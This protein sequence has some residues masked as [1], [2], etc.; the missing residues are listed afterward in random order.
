MPEHSRLVKMRIVNFGCI[1]PEGLEIE[2]NNII[3]LV[4]PNNTGKTTV[5]RAYEAAVN[6]EKLNE[7]EI[8]IDADGKTTNQPTSVEIWVHLPEAVTQDYIAEKW[9]KKEGDL[10]LVL[11][12]WEWTF[13]DYKS[14]R[15]TWDPEI[16]DYASDEKAAGFDSKFSSRLP[17]P[18][19]IKALTGPEAEHKALLSLILEPIENKLKSLIEDQNSD[20]KKAMVNVKNEAKK[21]V[22]L[23]N[24][25]IQ[26]IKNKINQ[27][28]TR[29]FPSSEL[30][31]TIDL[32]DIDIKPMT[33]LQNGSQID[34]KEKG[35]TTNYLQQGT[36]AQRALFWS[37][38]E[39][40]S[41]LK[42]TNDEKKYIE[43]KEAELSK[44]IE[45]LT[46][47]R[48]E[49]VKQFAIDKAN[50]ELQKK[51][52]ELVKIQASK[53]GEEEEKRGPIGL[54]GY[55]LLIDEPEIALHPNAIRSAK[56]YLYD[57]ANDSGWH[58]M[59]STHSPAFIDPLKDH[60]TIVRLTR[61][62]THPTPKTY[63]SDTL[64]FAEDDLENLK[65]L[66]KFDTSL[67][68]M[69]FGAYPIIIEGDTEYAAFQKIMEI[70]SDEY[71]MGTRPLLIRSRGK[72]TICLIIKILNHFKVPYSVLHD[73]DS[74]KTKRGEK[75]NSAWSANK[76][77]YNDI[78]DGRKKGIRIIHRVSIPNFELQH[79]GKE[80]ESEKP[81]KM[82]KAVQEDPAIK[83]SIKQILDALNSSEASE[84]PFEGDYLD[85]LKKR[86]REWAQV[87]ASDDLRFD[88]DEKEKGERK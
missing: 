86:V 34:I 50:K 76:R 64:T 88:F 84:G 57:L 68:E 14:V 77:I 83:E 32:E 41:E 8:Y 69:F 42:K 78:L 20:L 30:L 70:Y 3:A 80:E 29:I 74:P 36:G 72:D 12:K 28:Y 37:M 43:T 54:P 48:D 87:N 33:L 27:S 2:L 51:Q 46:K 18:L 39:V 7:S 58:V 53:K 66:L 9:I 67:A 31:L 52:A 47:K 17:Q 85:S 23:F 60:T 40:H 25:E 13:P 45:K 26:R 63:R 6:N 81:Y 79:C 16:E 1:G 38:L 82:A 11:S 49:L 59:L 10:R 55:M 21:P 61:T 5:L 65:L 62:E 35:K 56:E 4:G 15:T 24:E 75:K 71:P 22:S 19:R 73:A 44:D